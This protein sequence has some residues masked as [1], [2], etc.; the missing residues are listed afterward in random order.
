MVPRR[1]SPAARSRGHFSYPWRLGAAEKE[2]FA[3]GVASDQQ[4]ERRLAGTR[5]SQKIIEP[6]FPVRSP[7]AMVARGERYPGPELVE[8]PRAHSRGQGWAE[9]GAGS[10]G[11]RPRHPRRGVLARSAPA[12]GQNSADP[13]D[14]AEVASHAR[15][16]LGTRFDAAT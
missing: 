1:G 14:A 13:R 15:L 12:H 4:P 5:W 9:S 3:I 8:R 7:R 2:R 11:S 10:D 16:E 6:T